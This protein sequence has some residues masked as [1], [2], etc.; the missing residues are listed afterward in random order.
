MCKKICLFHLL[1]VKFIFLFAQNNSDMPSFKQQQIIIQQNGGNTQSFSIEMN[2]DQVLINGVPADEFKDSGIVIK[3]NGQDIFSFDSQKNITEKVD[4][5]AF[6]GLNTIKNK[7]GAEVKNIETNSPAE[8]SK[9]QIGDVI[10]S[11]NGQL[12]SDPSSLNS[13][14]RT[15]KPQTE[16]EITYL[17]HEQQV[18]EVIKLGLKKIKE[19]K[20]IFTDEDL[21]LI[22]LR[23]GSN[24]KPKLGV[25]LEDTEENAGV[26][27]IDVTDGSPAAKAGLMVGDIVTKIDEAEVN[28]VSD[29]KKGF[30]KAYQK[31]S[32]KIKFERSGKILEKSVYIPQK[33][34]T[35]DL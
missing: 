31:D 21:D 17:H 8:K 18:K 29:A 27:V 10:T 25:R 32:F 26:R 2:G 19:R 33:P 5:V 30:Y 23:T 22:I 1:L 34:R 24:E 28:Q 14:I 4:S 11:I 20:L 16:V 35:V 12:V 13:I 9:L 3:R 6:L 15:Q 7:D